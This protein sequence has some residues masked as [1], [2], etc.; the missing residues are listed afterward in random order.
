MLDIDSVV[1]DGKETYGVLKAGLVLKYP[2]KYAA[3]DPISKEYFIGN[4][5]ADAVTAGK[6]KYPYR[7]FYTVKI[8]EPAAIS[9][10]K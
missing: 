7:E 5:I 3:I 4:N 8:G 10:R 2:G 6:A 1:A 9:F